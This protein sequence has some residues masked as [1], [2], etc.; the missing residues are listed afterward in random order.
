MHPQEADKQL[1][2]VPTTR[3][4]PANRRLGGLALAT[5]AFAVLTGCAGPDGGASL[6]AAPPS[7][8]SPSATESSTAGFAPL[9]ESAP[10]SLSIPSVRLESSLI[11]LGLNPDGTVE[12]PSTEPGAPAGWYTGSPTPGELGPSIVL[13]HVNATDGGPG[14]F[15]DLR[16]MDSDDVINVT[17]ADGS[18]AVFRFRE[19]HQYSKSNFPTGL[20]YGDTPGA[21]LRLIT[22]DGY[23]PA[24]GSYDDNYVVYAELVDAR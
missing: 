7:A 18:V 16:R 17:R 14:V 12:V 23:N 15:A 2:F 9:A 20:V 5:V 11:D 8:S 4:R 21:E 6:P 10:V 3:D 24:T 1:G 19:S 13:G 22:C